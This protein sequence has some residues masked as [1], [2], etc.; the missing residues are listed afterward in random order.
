MHGS[1]FRNQKETFKALLMRIMFID[2]EISI[3][4]TLQNALK[5]LNYECDLFEDPTEGIEA[6]K[7]KHYD[8]V[9]TDVRMPVIDGIEILKLVKAINPDAYVVLIS[10]Y[11]D[12]KGTKDILDN[13]AY[14]LFRK[15][16]N[17]KEFIRILEKIENELENDKK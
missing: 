1:V 8:V 5:P 14:A 15:P 12:I 11:P 9:I 2:D 7:N 16:L 13:N 10:A 3:I 17:F 4:K 6:Y